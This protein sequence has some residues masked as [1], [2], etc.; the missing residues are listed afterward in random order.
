[1]NKSYRICLALLFVSGCNYS[2]ERMQPET[3]PENNQKVIAPEQLT[4]KMINDLVLQKA[5]LRCHSNEGG[6]KG[7]IN[8]ES[9]TDVFKNAHQIRLEVAGLTMP[10]NAKLSEE[11]IKLVTDWIDVGATEKG[12]QP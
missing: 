8:L 1:M 2:L 10:P 12:K 5:C 11:Q 4:F 7:R 6:N 9:Y 3:K